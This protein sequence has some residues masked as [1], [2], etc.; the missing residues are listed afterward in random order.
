MANAHSRP[1]QSTRPTPRNNGT[2]GQVLV[3]FAAGLVVFL[4]FVALS[5][6]VGRYVWARTQM[7]AAVDAAA[8]AGAQSMPNSGEA[9][10][11]A[12][13]YWLDNSGFIQAQGTNVQFS[14]S[15]PAGNMAISAQ[16]EADIP[17]WFARFFGVNEWHVT[18]E[19]EAEAMVVDAVLVIDRSGSMCWDSHG[20]NGSYVSQTKLTSTLDANDTTFTVTKNNALTPLDEYLYV[21]QVFRL[22]SS[23]STEWLEITNL[24]E[25]D[26]VEVTRSVPSPVN[27][28]TYPATAHPGGRYLR[29]SSCQ[30]AGVGPF[31][32]WEEVKNGAQVFVGEFNSGYDRIGF[33]HFSTQAQ[34]DTGLTSNLSGLTASIGNAPDPTS[35]G[36]NDGRTN[37]AHGFYLG[38]QELIDNGR[39]NAELVVVLLSD[40]VANTYCTPTDYTPTCPSNSY[41]TSIARSRALE[42]AD[43][44]AANGVTVYTIGY[45]NQSDDAL[46]QEIADRTGGVFFKAPDDASLQAA[47]IA[48]AQLTQLQLTR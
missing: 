18:A 31:H 14:V 34:E 48:I 19:A 46:M 16:G 41:S 30:T 13:D 12:N 8:L 25:P 17:T 44:A 7:Q 20:P 45:G 36:G 1:N 6:D 33:V 24:T 9:M 21:G 15:F 43:Y 11:E 2:E 39:A 28:L 40:G 23:S 47:F 35:N 38:T 4:G 10:S 42:Q 26:T 37:I 27:G 3:L 32:P 5:V 22:E 29:G